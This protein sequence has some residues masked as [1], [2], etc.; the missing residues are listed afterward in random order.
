MLRGE[1]ADTWVQIVSSDPHGPS[2]AWGV[3]Q[4]ATHICV[5]GPGALERLAAEGPYGNGLAGTRGRWS[6]NQ[7]E[8]WLLLG[9]GQHASV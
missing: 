1:A 4:Q 6:L 8:C 5:V 9:K 7:P 2:L 3:D